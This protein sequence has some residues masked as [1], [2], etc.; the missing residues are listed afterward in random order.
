MMRALPILILA[1]LALVLAGGLLQRGKQSSASAPA[2]GFS[3]PMVGRALEP[4]ELPLL[5]A[6]GRLSPQQWRGRPVVLNIFASWCESCIAEHALLLELSKHAE[7][8][9]IGWKDQPEKLAK[10][11]AARGNPYRAVGVDS[12]GA[13]TVAL[14][15]S[16]V[17][18]TF[19]ITPDGTVAYNRKSALTQD[20]INEE[21][22]PLL[23]KLSHD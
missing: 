22:L 7:I 8:I 17:P 12:N 1:L 4:F 16:G 6:G 2:A 5:E 3:S 21:I 9:G 14:G 15:L 18:E 10:W 20:H 23:K 13:T 19:V 11:L